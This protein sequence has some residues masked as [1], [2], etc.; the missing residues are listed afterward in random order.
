MHRS[1]LSAR[2]F[3]DAH[4]PSYW[5]DL[6][7]Q[8]EHLKRYPLYGVRV[9][10]EGSRKNDLGIPSAYDIITT[11]ILCIPIKAIRNYTWVSNDPS[12]EDIISSGILCVPIEWVIH[13]TRGQRRNIR[14]KGG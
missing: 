6:H 13:R 9:G 8:R 14:V 11:G 12:A 4:C 2:T 10:Y 3:I 7:I 5:K 1:L